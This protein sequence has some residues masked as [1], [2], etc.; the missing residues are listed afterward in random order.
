[1]SLAAETRAAVRARP[2]LLDALRADVINFSAA[3][4]YLDVGDPEAVA[5]ALRRYADELGPL[6]DPTD[7]RLQVR[8]ERGFGQGDP[9]EALLVVG[10][11]AF[12]PD[13]GDLTAVFI[14]GDVDTARFGRI[15]RRLD[16]ADVAVHAAA[17]SA[18]LAVVVVPG[19]DGPKAL[20][21]IDDPAA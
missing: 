1:M 7:A 3:A 13:G 16:V 18:D 19:S 9:A 15:L 21:T 4:R 2:F 11:C 20:Q 10:E 14:R 17:L 12:V 5:A 8:M 6:E